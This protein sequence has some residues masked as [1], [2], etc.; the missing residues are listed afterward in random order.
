MDL[1][2]GTWKISFNAPVIL[3]LVFITLIVV[4]ISNYLVNLAPLFSAKATVALLAPTYYL[5]L[6]C[7]PLAHANWTHWFGNIMFLLLLGPILEEKYGSL[8]LLLMIVVTAVLTGLLNSLFFDASLIGAS[9]IVFM[10]MILISFAN[11]KEK[12]IPLSFIL[13][14]LIFLGQ[15]I[16]ASFKPDHVSQFG[17][18]I[19]GLCGGAFGFF[20]NK[21]LPKKAAIA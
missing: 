15:E 12:Q 9:G 8:R 14:V 4:I 7:H 21:I 18:I 16:I 13:V 3:T 2:I 19:G 5:G 10:L 17:H 1:R 11:V 6:L 20:L